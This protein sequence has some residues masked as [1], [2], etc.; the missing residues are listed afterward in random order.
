MG[1]FSKKTDEQI[2]AEG[3]TLYIKG[4]LSGASLKL[5]KIAHKGNPEACYL[6]AKIHLE[7]ADK[8]ERELYTKSA[9]GFLEKAVAAGHKGAAVLMEQKFGVPNPY[10]E[11]CA[12]K[13]AAVKTEAEARG[14]AEAEEQARK[15]SE[16]VRA[17]EVAKE[18]AKRKAE[19]EELKRL[20]EEKAKA[21][22]AIAELEKPAPDSTEKVLE[23]IHELENKIEDA[24]AEKLAELEAMESAAE[25]KTDEPEEGRMEEAESVEEAS[26]DDENDIAMKNIEDA[27]AL[28]EEGK[29]DE[30]IAVWREYGE[31]GY[32]IAVY[33][34]AMALGEKEEYYEALAWAEKMQNNC[35]DE[36][37]RQVANELIEKFERGITKLFEHGV[38]LYRAGNYEEALKQFKPLAEQAHASAQYNL[39]I[40]YYNGEGTEKNHEEALKWFKL[41]AGGDFVEAGYNAALMYYKGDGIP[42]DKQKALRWFEVAAEDGHVEAPFWLALMYMKGDGVEK[43]K[44][45]ELY[46]CRK[47]FDMALELPEEE[48]KNKDALETAVRLYFEDHFR[49]AAE[50]MIQLWEEKTNHILE[51]CWF[52]MKERFDIYFEEFVGQFNSLNNV[53]RH[54]T[55]FEL[56]RSRLLTKEQNEVLE[57]TYNGISHYDQYM[58]TKYMLAKLKE[59]LEWLKEDGD[60]LIKAIEEDIK[61]LEANLQVALIF[62]RQEGQQHKKEGNYSEAMKCFEVLAL[63]GDALSQALLAEMYYQGKGVPVD[64]AKAFSWYIASAE[65]GVSFAQCN[66]GIMYYNGEGTQED[67]Q[68]GVKWI[69]KA[70]EQ[71]HVGAKEILD[72]IL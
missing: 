44:E 24:F 17:E 15:E 1:L 70:A 49:A 66:L 37:I 42:E 18:E 65:Q 34:V 36:E 48:I 72:K 11:D 59:D 67:I 46:W 71:G 23:D 12:K 26:E 29:V 60:E 50:W 38:N 2:I 68:E 64:Y 62:V 10:A 31:K 21:E 27:L 45:K 28:Y 61:H 55:Y 52:V 3:R 33:Y 51:L 14:K 6:I 63:D 25:E 58:Y 7:I 41:A 9:K 53:E 35:P 5:M 56:R 16:R 22:A 20:K 8:R 39:A 69:K 40:M 54:K 57:Q 19:A 4:D 43:N 30:A 32:L 13:E 47:L